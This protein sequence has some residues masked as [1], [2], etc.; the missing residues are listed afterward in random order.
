MCEI[1]VLTTFWNYAESI[2]SSPLSYLNYEAFLSLEFICTFLLK[3]LGKAL[4]VCLSEFNGYMKIGTWR[5]LRKVCLME[6]T[7]YFVLF[8]CLWDSISL[9]WNSVCTTS[10]LKTCESPAL[11]SQVTDLPL[12]F[13]CKW[14]ILLTPK[15]KLLLHLHMCVHVWE[16]CTHM[17]IIMDTNQ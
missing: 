17:H 15:L 2:I 16:C 3:K 7:F 10:S 13:I 12:S 4:L 9:V 11:A 14:F 6:L 8:C 5:W 1:F